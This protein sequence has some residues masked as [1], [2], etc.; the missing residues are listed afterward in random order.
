MLIPAVRALRRVPYFRGR[1]R[2]LDALI[3]RLPAEADVTIDGVRLRLDT[4]ETTQAG[5]LIG[6]H[7]EPLTVAALRRLLRPGDTFVDVGAHAGVLSMVAAQAVG[8]TGCVLA[9]EPQP[10]LGDR[11]LTNASLNGARQVVLVQAAVS[12][13]DGW[14]TLHMQRQGDRSRLSLCAHE[15]NATEYTFETPMVRLDSLLSRRGVEHVR[16][17]K[18]DVEG[19][20]LAVLRGCGDRL[21][22]VDAVIAELLPGDAHADTLSLLSAAGFTLQDVTG[23]AFGSVDALPEHNLLAVRT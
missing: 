12:D 1:D 15:P 19:H 8:P 4:R 23:A 11:L 13:V 9:I 20:E 3:A 18:V 10:A 22:D 21:R 17:L 7:L 16:V 5:L 14:V 6:G 2:A